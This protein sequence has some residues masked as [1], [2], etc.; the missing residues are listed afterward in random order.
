M[1]KYNL[2]LNSFSSETFQKDKYQNKYL[3][4][5]FKK[6]TIGFYDQD[7]GIYMHNLFY[8]TTFYS[9]IILKAFHF[10]KYR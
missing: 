9:Y 2:G 8:K 4:K 3:E 1:T 5:E 7:Y 6:D 10:E